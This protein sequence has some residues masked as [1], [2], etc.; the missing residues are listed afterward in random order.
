MA[1]VLTLDDVNVDGKTV[2]LRVDINS[3]LDPHQGL[4][5]RHEIRAIL[6]TLQK[7]VKAKVI[8]LAHQSAPAKTTSP[9]PWVTPVNWAACSAVKSSG[10]T[11]FTVPRP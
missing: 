10:S 4:P 3:P 1:K 11:T 2:L 6:P 7:L 9:A 5:R 8:L